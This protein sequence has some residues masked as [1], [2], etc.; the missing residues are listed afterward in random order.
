MGLNP[1][2]GIGFFFPAFVLFD[3]VNF[4]NDER[5]N[6]DFPVLIGVK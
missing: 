2:R 4:S 6:F 3:K 1:A 5:R